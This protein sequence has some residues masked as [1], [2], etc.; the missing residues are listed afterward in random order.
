MLIV[1][2]HDSNVSSGTLIAMLFICLLTTLVPTCSSSPSESSR[3]YPKFDVAPST[4]VND[5]KRPQPRLSGGTIARDDVSVIA[6]N[7]MH[8]RFLKA[9]DDDDNHEDEEALDDNHED[10]EYE[11]SEQSPKRRSHYGG[12]GRQ[13]NSYS[14]ASSHD[15]PSSSGRE[16]RSY[17]APRSPPPPQH[18]SRDPADGIAMPSLDVE[19]T[20]IGIPDLSQYT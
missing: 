10:E 3:V 14:S 2:R 19:K 9:V 5:E 11:H 17:G 8:V 18:V 1:G 20:I 6:D 15:A 7:S 13:S 4:A 12:G 16:H